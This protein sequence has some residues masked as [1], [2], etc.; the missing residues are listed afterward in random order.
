MRACTGA[1]FIHVTGL[2]EIPA[3]FSRA[4]LAAQDDCPASWPK[5]E[6]QNF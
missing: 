5:F 1:L 3:H 4:R 2:V 6:S